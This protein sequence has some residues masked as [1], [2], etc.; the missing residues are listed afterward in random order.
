[1][2]VPKR[3]L[4]DI[5]NLESRPSNDD[6]LLDD[7]D[8][9]NSPPRPKIEATARLM[10]PPEKLTLPE[11]SDEERRRYLR[12]SSQIVNTDETLYKTPQDN[13]ARINY[14]FQNGDAISL[15]RQ[16]RHLHN[17]VKLLEEEVQT[18]HNRQIF[19]IG[20]LS[21]YFLSKGIKLMCR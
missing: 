9:D 20:V 8:Y 21:V 11:I 1:M 19:L 2:E 13:N 18:Q 6:F 5:N 16:V 4:V 12:D 14:S 17:R 15:C 3:I 10:S 7:D